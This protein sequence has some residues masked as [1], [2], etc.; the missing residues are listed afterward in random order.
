MTAIREGSSHDHQPCDRLDNP[1][2]LGFG[3][4]QKRPGALCEIT[5]DRE[6]HIR[7][8]H[9]TFLSPYAGFMLQILS[10]V[11]AN[12]ELSRT[13]SAGVGNDAAR[14]PDVKAAL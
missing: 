6:T 1:R 4:G 7:P 10:P 5:I 14:A 12:G 3:R 9:T 11:A 8:M 13:G 2:K